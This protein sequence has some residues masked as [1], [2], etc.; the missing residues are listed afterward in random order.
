MNGVCLLQRE[1]RREGG[2][3]RGKLMWKLHSTLSVVNRQQEEQVTLGKREWDLVRLHSYSRKK[4]PKEVGNTLT[5]ICF[6]RPDICPL[7]GPKTLSSWVWSCSFSL[8]WSPRFSLPACL[9]FT[10]L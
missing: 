4:K 10:V 6:L 7:A 8:R 1:Q 9:P 3:L 5:G 2:R